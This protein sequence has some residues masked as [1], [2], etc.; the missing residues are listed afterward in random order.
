MKTKQKIAILMAV[1][2]I[3]LTICTADAYAAISE[4]SLKVH[5][6]DGVYYPETKEGYRRASNDQLI[7]QLVA[8]F[9]DQTPVTKENLKIGTYP[10][11]ESF[12]QDCVKVPL[13]NKYLCKYI[14]TSD[15]E[16]GKYPFKVSL[17]S[18]T[19]PGPTTTAVD[20]TQATFYADD[21][22]PSIEI[23]DVTPLGENFSVR[24]KLTDNACDRSE[25][26][27]KCSGIMKVEFPN[28]EPRV[29]ELINTSDCSIEKTTS[30]YIAGTG[31]QPITLTAVDMVNNQRTE[32]SQSLFV[33]H[34]P[35]SIADNFNILRGGK[36]LGYISTTAPDR[37]ITGAEVSVRVTEENI[38]QA[39][40][41]L[42]ELNSFSQL[43]DYS[44]VDAVCTQ[45]SGGYICRWSDLNLVL[46]SERPRIN[47]TVIDKAGYTVSKEVTNDLLIDNTAPEIT[48]LG[49]ENCIND[50]CYITEKDNKVIARITEIESGFNQNFSLFGGT[51]AGKRMILDL[52]EIKGGAT[53]NR[54]VFADECTNLGSEWLCVWN[55][56]DV[57]PS[58]LGRSS[59]G[60][61]VVEGSKDD[62]QNSV[63][64]VKTTLL[65]F[66]NTKPV[67][68]E[69]QVVPISEIIGVHGKL[70]G[71]RPVTAA[72]KIK[73]INPVTGYADF[74]EVIT[75]LPVQQG[76]CA[77]VEEGTTL[78]LWDNVGIAKS[79]TPE[80]P[81]F[82]RR[83]KF[84]FK[85]NLGNEAVN[86][87]SV[88]V[89]YQETAP[90]NYWTVA[91]GVPS[92]SKLDRVLI[93]K[94]PQRLYY[95]LVM[96]KTNVQDVKVLRVDL[97]GCEGG[98][99]D[100]IYDVRII[101]GAESPWLNLILKPHQVDTKKIEYNF[102]CRFK[103]TSIVR[104]KVVTAPELE[105]VT[106]NV[107]FYDSG[108]V[109]ESDLNA[110]IEDEKNDLVMRISDNGLFKSLTKIMDTLDMI[111]KVAKLITMVKD[112]FDKV[113][114]FF[115]GARAAGPKGKV[116][117]DKKQIG[118]RKSIISFSGLDGKR[119]FIGAMYKACA[120]LSCELGGSF[121][122]VTPKETTTKMWNSDDVLKDSRGFPLKKDGFLQT[123]PN[124]KPVGT[125][126]GVT[127]KDVSGPGEWFYENAR[128]SADMGFFGRIKKYP[129]D[130]KDSLALSIATLCIPGILK[131][132]RELRKVKCEYIYCLKKRVP[133][134]TPISLCEYQKDYAT[135]K[136]IWGEL[137]SVIP[138]A[139]SLQDAFKQLNFALSHPLSTIMG[140]AMQK[141]QNP[142]KTPNKTNAGFRVVC[143]LLIL[144]KA[145]KKMTEDLKKYKDKSA[146]KVDD[147]VCSILD[148]V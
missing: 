114:V 135:C 141:L 70:I 100:K 77:V 95:K 51:G 6:L 23:L 10:D 3:S 4:E 133:A 68:D 55:D 103:I 60:V 144:P 131:K 108:L 123:K 130:P 38:S 2:M 119:G 34:T 18:T 111:C 85:D 74:S 91:G 99:S 115:D 71:G 31:M 148:E 61:H 142:C 129:N 37:I 126:R 57:D 21:I 54:R 87:T 98:D 145:I 90:P 15:F 140:I 137:F 81:A 101:Q 53:A 48:F 107:P 9:S 92:P 134:G 122:K 110:K 13:T 22:A 17:Y 27:G 121:S 16:G 63:I 96:E 42:R 59:Y 50:K 86:I 64:G 25:C 80:M 66:D 116:L 75:D 46:G 49:T 35:P 45:E 72:A 104:N 73:D 127:V 88:D 106:L 39:Y 120:F 47:V 65:F 138:F 14:D 44:R 118:A 32:S 58:F 19:S 89:L 147:S 117:A 132:L 143:G 94:I 28:S 84:T 5:G 43:E 40:A 124:A 41:D 33:D 76:E 36:T 128:Q 82:D 146:W 78:C 1:L 29:V 7:L 24:Y 109:L 113:H 67:V 136:Y 62:A 69:I 97:E 112:I 26:A 12:N 139:K 11:I 93:P 83:I 30:V 20:S 102:Q 8:E 125:Q 52:T 56:V 105:N 79:V